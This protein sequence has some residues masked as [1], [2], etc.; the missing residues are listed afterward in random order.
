[1]HLLSVPGEDWPRVYNRG[2]S[3]SEWCLNSEHE[4]E[5]EDDNE[6]EYEH[7]YE[8][9]TAQH[10]TPKQHQPE[11]PMSFNRETKITW[12]GHATFLIDTPGGKRIMIDPFLE[13]NPKCPAEF[14]TI[15]R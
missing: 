10:P 15:D 12:L 5:R 1:M 11:N 13:N 6:Y 3:L 9:D 7:D 2:E 4:H 8:Y 14:K